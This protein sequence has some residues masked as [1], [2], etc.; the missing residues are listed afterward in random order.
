MGSSASPSP[1]RG[2]KHPEDQDLKRPPE[3]ITDTGDAI[4]ETVDAITE[5]VDESVAGAP[6]KGPHHPQ[7]Q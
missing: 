4:T 6:A 5:T 7:D 1:E 3:A 2:P